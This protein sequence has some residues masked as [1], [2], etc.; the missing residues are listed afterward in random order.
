MASH[1]RL[2]RIRPALAAALLGAAHVIVA[3]LVFDPTPHTGGDNAA[4]L[5][6]A[7][8]ILERGRYLDYWDPRLPAHTQYPPVFPL[9]L[10]FFRWVGFEAWVSFKMVIVGCSGI[11]VAFSY[12]WV[13][14]WHSASLALPIGLIVAFSPGVLG[15]SHWVLSDVPFWALLMVALWAFAAVDGTAIKRARLLR[16]LEDAHGTA[17][18]AVAERVRLANARE[19]AAITRANRDALT[20]PLWIG[21]AA[22]TLAYFT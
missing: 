16:L 22:L 13:R 4:Y 7:T 17:S 15:L 19:L 12:L 20:A 14:R 3:L 21:I 1:P 10:A 8:S 18:D 11:A 9:I 2:A 6:L 5:S